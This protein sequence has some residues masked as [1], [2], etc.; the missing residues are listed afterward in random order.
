MTCA[1]HYFE[2]LLFYGK[3]VKDNA[4][5]DSLTEPEQKA[6]EMCAQYVIWTLFNGKDNLDRFLKLKKKKT[7]NGN[8]FKA[9]FP[10]MQ[11]SDVQGYPEVSGAIE[12]KELTGMTM[13]AMREWWNAPYEGGKNESYINRIRR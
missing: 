2:N 13:K 10:D 8:I 7:T 5:K 3:D 11:I 4:N 1:E 12:Y 9:L 6:I